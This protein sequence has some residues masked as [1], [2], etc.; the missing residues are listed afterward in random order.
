MKRNDDRKTVSA[1][2]SESLGAYFKRDYPVL[3]LLFLTLAV[4]VSLCFVKISTTNT[5]A[6][7]N[8]D[9]YEVGQIADVT[10]KAIKTLPADY[11]NP[12]PIEKGEKVIRKG[13]PITEDGYAKLKKMS[14]SP[15][16]IDYRAFANSIIYHILMVVLFFFFFSRIYFKTNMIEFKELVTECVFYVIIFAS[17][18]F[19]SKLTYF[20]SPFALCAIIPA[21]LFIF[22]IAILFGQL[23]AVFFAVMISLAVLN[24]TSYQIVPFLFVLSTSFASSRLVRK[25]DRRTDMVFVSVLQAVLNAVFLV[26]FKIVFNDSFAN[27]IGAI[28]GV[29]LNGFFSGILCLGLLTPLELL[30]NTASV[31]RLM[32]LSDLNNPFMKKMLVTA[33]GTYNHSLMVAS[34]AEAACNEVGANPLLARVGAYYHDIGKMDN[35]EYFVENQGGGENI[36]KEINP[37]LSASVIRTHVKRGIE[38]AHSLRLPK[39]VIDIISE[40]HGNQVIAYFYNEALKINPDVSPEDYSYTGNPPSTKESAVV[41]LAD[42][43]EAACRSLDKPSVPRLEKFI[44]TLIT[45][46][47]DQKQLEDCNLTFNDI[48]KI[49]DAFVQILAGYYHSRTKYP[50]QKDPDGQQSQQNN[51]EVQPKVQPE[52]EKAPEEKESKAEEKKSEVKKTEEKKSLKDKAEKVARSTR[53]KKEK[54]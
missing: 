51:S 24:A 12:I 27:G 1:I 26:I 7:F 48:T 52:T 45:A 10:I 44:T 2:I 38:K 23:N 4:T 25:I 9:D 53:E 34:L 33:S 22:L 54:N 36:H 19:G 20:S 17:V 41:M 16:Y 35:P 6:S 21:P 18:I 50:D 28:V 3:L 11:D 47:I 42:T 49:H 8:I 37:S 40:H 39:P 43:V 32:D 31:F 14:E 5:I 30:L 13:F 46:K 15:V 29:I